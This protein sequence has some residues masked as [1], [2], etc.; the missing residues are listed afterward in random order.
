[1]AT[2]TA[3]ID[4]L[5]DDYWD[6]EFVRNS[7]DCDNCGANYDEMTIQWDTQ[8]HTV[9]ISTR[10]GCYGGEYYAGPEQEAA[11]HLYD[12][13][14]SYSDTR[15]DIILGYANWFDGGVET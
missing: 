10:V 13:A 2:F 4:L 5:P 6:D 11:K 7:Y 3:H 8:T 9:E 12:M 15:N 14:D 1:M